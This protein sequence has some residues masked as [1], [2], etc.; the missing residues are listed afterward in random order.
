MTL[1]RQL[2]V[3]MITV[4]I[5]LMA[6][7]LVIEF[8]TT[9]DNLL[10]QQRSEINNTINTVGL[11][12]TPYLQDKDTVATESVLNA[13]FDGSSYSVVKLSFLDSDQVIERKYP[14][15]SANVPDWFTN[16]DLFQPVEDTRILTSGWIQFAE[17]TIISQTAAIY[18]QLWD[19]FI[20]LISAIGL[21]FLFGMLCISAIL[22]RA[23]R[24]L[25]AITA[26]MRDIAN[27][28][29]GQPLKAPSTTDLIAVVD[30]INYM[31]A[32]IEA[33]FKEQAKEAQNLRQQAYIDPVSNLGNRSYFLTQLEQWLKEDGHGGIGVLHAEYISE[34]YDDR[35]YQSADQAV[36]SLATQLTNS[37]AVVNQQVMIARISSD[38]FGFIFPNVDA[39]ELQAIAANIVHDVEM[40]GTDPTGSA[41][42]AIALG[43]AYNSSPK[44]RGDVL[45]M[46]DN[47][48]SKAKAAPE[49]KF[50]FVS[51]DT[52]AGLMGKQQWKTLVEE[53]I[54]EKWVQFRFQNA[55]YSNGQLF[56]REAFSLI[57]KD[58][59]VYRA[60]QYL[61]ALEQLEATAM[62]DQHVISSV[63]EK[64]EQEATP[65]PTAINI[66]RSSL[67]EPSFIRF[68]S[69]VLANHPKI[70]GFL[71]FEI[72]EESF[73][74]HP[75]YCALFCNAIRQGGA[76]FGVDNYG[77]H[78][79]SLDYLNEF[80]PNY[81]KLDYLFTHNLDD[82]KQKFTLTSISR[83]AQNLGITTIASRVETQQQ[84][85][86]LSDHFVRV[87]QGFI[88]EQ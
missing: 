67:I 27:N 17:V 31:S 38:E 40:L 29:F 77:R 15:R 83:T 10:E 8:N 62:F 25:K 61:F 49:D 26:K 21:T 36:R 20:K 47:A 70:A 28:Q 14:Q 88:F 13:L 80:R 39:D 54:H 82:E 75:N 37:A 22:H 18:E 79:Q 72:G 30:G 35:D 84:L 41:D 32:Q 78:F 56:H 81:V 5:F 57:Q 19:A 45:S 24:P 6:A 76:S 53:A 33:S 71:H 46:I 87:F 73:I 69:Q 52:V 59:Q 68:V 50:G 12:L 55:C 44:S 3:G 58:E 51:S 86:F 66:A 1:Y 2:V 34:A 74:H 65:T 9:R 7:V 42:M 4:F 85:D 43:V 16:L 48:L 64:L 23:L 63:V 60:T 11:A